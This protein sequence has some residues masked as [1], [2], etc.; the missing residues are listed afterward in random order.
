MSF[1]EAATFVWERRKCINPNKGFVRILRDWEKE[2]KV[3][4]C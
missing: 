4:T 3:T 2:V 1:E